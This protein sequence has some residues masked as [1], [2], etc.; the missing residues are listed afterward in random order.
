MIF[1]LVWLTFLLLLLLF[2]PNNMPARLIGLGSIILLSHVIYAGYTLMVRLPKLTPPEVLPAVLIGGL[3]LLSP[4]FLK[5]YRLIAGD[6]SVLF[7]VAIW[8]HRRVLRLNVSPRLNRLCRYKINLEVAII[9]YV[10]VQTILIWIVKSHE[11]AILMINIGLI[12]LAN[13]VIILRHKIYHDLI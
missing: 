4:L 11:S 13:L 8:L 3:I 1:G 2:W 10:A 5:D 9:C 6:F 12:I 7:L